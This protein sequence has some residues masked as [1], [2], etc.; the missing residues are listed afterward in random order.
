MDARNAQT[1]PGADARRHPDATG[2]D[3]A[4]HDAAGHSAPDPGRPGGAEPA[5]L[6]GSI[7]RHVRT[8]DTSWVLLGSL[9]GGLGAYLFQV[10]ATRGLGEEAYAPIS[11]LWTIQFL[12]LSIPMVSLE[13][14]VTREISLG[15]RVRRGLRAAVAAMVG[16]ALLVGIAGVALAEHLFSGYTDFG[17]VAGALV[18]AFGGFVIARGHF[19]GQERFRAYGMSTGGESVLRLLLLVAVLAVA[20]SPRS[21]AWILPVGPIVVTLAFLL[22]RSRRARGRVADRTPPGPGLQPPTTVAAPGSAEPSPAGTEL[23]TDSQSTGFLAATTVANAAAQVLLAG[24]P[25][26]MIALGAGPVEVSIFF[27]TITAARTPL[28]FAIGGVLSRLLPPLSRVVQRGDRHALRRLTALAVGATLAGAV[29][30]AGAAAL[31]GAEAIALFFGEGFRP[32]TYFVTVTAAASVLATGNLALNQVL[33]ALAD[34]RHLPAPWLS[35][36]AVA[37]TVALF[38]G[39]T[40]T[41]RVIT[42][43]VLGE[44]V[45]LVGLAATVA[46]RSQPRRLATTADGNM[47]GPWR[48]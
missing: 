3:A 24:G 18:L 21:V 29:V 8:A 13:S 1:A 46:W 45:A 40:A 47:L 20:A 15:H 39:G 22:S 4:G 34:E 33:I 26:L 28:V 41:D 16:L 6:L 23:G 25:L 17:A 38:M 42:G 5:G 36:L 14:W 48:P 27:V 19:A 11:V 7:G 31:V 43:L 10:V 44:I 2:H 30:A 35:G 37:L 12:V 9:V 32:G